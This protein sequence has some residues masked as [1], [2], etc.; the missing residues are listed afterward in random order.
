MPTTTTT[1]PPGEVPG[2]P[3]NAAAVAS[4]DA[5]VVSWDPPA[6]AGDA[7]LDGYTVY[8]YDITDAFASCGATAVTGDPPATSATVTGLQATAAYR[9]AI[10][11]NNIH[12]ESSPSVVTNIVVPNAARAPNPPPEV[13]ALTG[14]GSVTI[15]WEEP[16]TNGSP[17]TGY[18][19][20]CNRAGV[21][22]GIRTTGPEVTGIA[23]TGLENGALYSFQVVAANDAGSSSPASSG[24]VMPAAQGPVMNTRLFQSVPIRV[25][26][27]YEPIAGDFN[28]DGR[29]DV[30]WYGPGPET[31]N[32][33]LANASGR[34]FRAA[35]TRPVNGTYVPTVGDF[36]GD[37]FDDI[38]WYSPGGGVEHV[39]RGSET[40][41]FIGRRVPDVDGNYVPIAGQFV[42]APDSPED[43]YF[44]AP[45]DEPEFMWT[46][47]TDGGFTAVGRP[48]TPADGDYQPLVG[49]FDGDL[50]DDIFW[51]GPGTEPDGLW[52][53][54]A[55]GAFVPGP[56]LAINGT[57]RPVVA[58]VTGDGRSDIL[59][60][61][62]GRANDAL[63]AA[64]TGG[65]FTGIPGIAV[66][67]V[68]EPFA[69]DL[70]GDG[71]EDIFW[72]APGGA[73]DYV[74]YTR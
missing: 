60:Y 6:R 12:G 2:S 33:W 20:F 64:T 5:A 42:G 29:T 73:P 31:D 44:Y 50:Y 30:Y 17:I 24:L 43:L 72:Y 56:D 68:Y 38:F 74:W 32:M 58:D 26:G 7:P 18:T 69:G 4:F 25:S 27:V 39:W 11:A 63:W 10:T 49:D 57:Y 8:C 55:N 62:P 19:V 52:L 21:G 15:N 59:W 46:G 48:G 66:N 14:D 16:A 51:Y 45:G 40:G 65:R 9:F 23:F 36:D 67:G 41:A 13:T 34:G 28:G 37:G 71:K 35:T 54:R 22:C 47:T 61:G 70:S 1:A 3:T 53:G